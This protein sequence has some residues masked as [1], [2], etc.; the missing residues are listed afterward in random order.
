M[1]IDKL[2]TITQIA[3]IGFGWVARDYMLPA[4][5]AHADATLCAVVSVRPADFEGLDRSVACYT[6]AAAMLA[7]E[8]PD[9]VYVAS[10]NH[11]HA[12]HVL[13]CARAGVDV[14]C[15]KP[16]AATY[17][18]AERLVHA[19][20]DAG[21]AFA[22]AYD[23]RHHPAHHL[24]R[25]VIAAGQLGT[26]T[27]ARIDYACWLPA[28]WSADNWR[29]DQA[30][31]GG[32]AIIDLA[33]HGLDLLEHL[34]DSTITDLHC[35]EQRAVQDYPVDDGGILTAR[36]ANDALAALSVAYNRP[37][38]LPR[39]RLEIT[40]TQGMLLAENT[41]GQ[42][43]GGTLTFIDAATGR[44]EA[45]AFDTTTGPFYHQLAAFL[46]YRKT[47]DG[48]N[49]KEDLRLAKLLDQAIAPAL[50]SYPT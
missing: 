36:F 12:A 42:T 45:L 9:A 2:P 4:I 37:E 21:I 31:A 11:L 50:N 30:K 29:I 19:A 20:L 17:A 38:T 23:Q 14:L 34:L 26:I 43:P 1:S 32:G 16:L 35:Y 47:R 3:I 6:D 15:E 25:E 10:P 33:P 41:M 13:L 48:R 28:D 40:G 7:S 27:Q 24:M 22:T 44:R 18:D 49:P 5:A 8:R 39:R 46:H